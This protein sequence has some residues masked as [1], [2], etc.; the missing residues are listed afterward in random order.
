M[1]SEKIFF[2]VYDQF[3]IFAYVQN[4]K[5]GKTMMKKVFNC[6]ENVQLKNMDIK[7]VNDTLSYKNDMKLYIFYGNGINLQ[8]FSSILAIF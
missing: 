3:H 1:H 4:K 6:R 8:H 7:E 5:C 2:Y